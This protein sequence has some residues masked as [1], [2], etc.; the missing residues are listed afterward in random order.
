M[1]EEHDRNLAALELQIN[2]QE[3]RL[4]EEENRR[5]AGIIREQEI[6]SMLARRIALLSSANG[7]SQEQQQAERLLMISRLA[8]LGEAPAALHTNNTMQNLAAAPLSSFVPVAPMNQS[9]RDETAQERLSRLLLL[10]QNRQQSGRAAEPP[11]L[12]G[13]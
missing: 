9:Q 2:L 12:N 3:E 8:L 1:Q 4:R 6:Q 5:V 13:G 7:I 11:N 10:L